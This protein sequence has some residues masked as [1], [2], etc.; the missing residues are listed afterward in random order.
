MDLTDRRAA[1][2]I[3]VESRALEEL[4]ATEAQE[5]LVP[6]TSLEGFALQ[7]SPSTWGALEDVPDGFWETPL[8]PALLERYL[9]LTPL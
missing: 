3:A 8:D 2:A 6:D 5:T 1:E 7:L 4:E 9:G